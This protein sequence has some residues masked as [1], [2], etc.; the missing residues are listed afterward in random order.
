MK[1]LIIRFFVAAVL[2]NPMPHLPSTKN[3]ISPFKGGTP[4]TRT[5]L[6][7]SA[8]WQIPS[9]YPSNWRPGVLEKAEQLTWKLMIRR[10]TALAKIL[11]T[12]AMRNLVDNYAPLN[13]R[14]F[15]DLENLKHF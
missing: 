12:A 1:F 14:Y 8:N 6:K 5:T 2:H 11:I 7:K 3:N 9:P 10:N 15:E 4:C 13:R